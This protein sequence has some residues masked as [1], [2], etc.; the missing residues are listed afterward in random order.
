MLDF[1]QTDF[2]LVELVVLVLLTF[3]FAM[4]TWMAN[5]IRSTEAYRDMV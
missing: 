4:A 3:G 1:L 2:S 5:V